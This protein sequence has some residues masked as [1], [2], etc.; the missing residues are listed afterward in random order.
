MTEVRKLIVD[1]RDH[2]YDWESAFAVGDA[3]LSDTHRLLLSRRCVLDDMWDCA[4]VMLNPSTADASTDDPTIRRCIGFARSW[5]MQR[6]VIANAYALRS[7]DP[8]GLW[9]SGDPVGP[10][11]DD[12]I[13][14][15]AQRST[16]VV[17]AWGASIKP[18]RQDRVRELLT[19]GRPDNAEP[20]MCLGTTKAGHPKHP[21]YLRSDTVPTPWVTA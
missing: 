15:V 17:V 9:R 10:L 6:L 7:T 1:A 11:N 12:A 20:V 16:R 4:F 3:L 8:R 21:L 13:R 5:G 14:L 18:E 2:G 19:S